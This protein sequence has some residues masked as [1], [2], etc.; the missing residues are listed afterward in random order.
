MVK[1]RSRRGFP[2][3]LHRALTGHS[4]PPGAVPRI[5]T[6]WTGLAPILVEQSYRYLI[7]CASIPL[8]EVVGPGRALLSDLLAN[9]GC[10]KDRRAIPRL[11][12]PSMVEGRSARPCRPPALLK[13]CLRIG[14]R[15][16]G[17]AAWD[18]DFKTA[19]VLVLLDLQA[20]QGRYARHFLGDVMN[21]ERVAS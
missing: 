20:L 2:F 8:S 18:L 16:C 9:H 13:A 6:L 4:P 15:V 3:N 1:V 7:G 5:A 17:E 21:K 14:A 10:A 11:P 12:L 19:D